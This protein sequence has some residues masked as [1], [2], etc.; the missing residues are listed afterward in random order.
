MAVLGADDEERILMLNTPFTRFITLGSLVCVCV[1]VAASTLPADDPPRSRDGLREPVFRVSKARIEAKGGQTPHPLDA[2]LKIARESLERIQTSVVDYSCTLIKQERINGV[3]RPEEYMFAE[4][5]NRKVKD[6][7]LVTP[8][9]AYLYFLK[10]GKLKGREVIF[11]EGQNNG[12]M[13]AHEGGFR[14]RVVPPIWLKPDG[15]FA[16]HGQLYPITEIGIETLIDRLIEKGERDRKRGECT[17]DF[18]KGAKINGRVCTVLQVKHPTPRPWF[19][20]HI[21]RI[22]I[23]DELKVPIRYAAYTWPKEAGGKP[24]LLEAYT[25]LNLKLN[26]QLTD[27]D[28]RHKEKFGKVPR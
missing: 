22:F 12:K 28:F 8:L 23:D 1:L 21:A 15:P 7:V 3:L 25:Y 13:V 4:I 24:Q 17:V 2:A 6:G 10:P 27:A 9:S 14:G 18:I 26:V 20:F 5:R 16:M 11:V 19:D